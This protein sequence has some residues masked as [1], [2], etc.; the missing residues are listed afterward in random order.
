MHSP[1]TLVIFGAWYF[2]RVVAEAAELCSWTVAGF[3]DPEPPE[4]TA[5]LNT[6]P[7]DASV[8][9]AIGD[10]TMRSYVHSRL[11]DSGRTFAT[12]TH[13]TASV[14][15]SAAVE[16]GCYLGEFACVRTNASVGAGTVLNSGSVVSHDCQIGEFVTFGPNAAAAGRAVVGAR[17]TIGVGASVRPRAV[18]G[19]DCQVGAGAAVVSDITDGAVVGGVPAKVITSKATPDKQSAW[20]TNKTW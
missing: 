11:V 6:I 17:S 18:V 13:P 20:H 8:I 2:A 19:C 1:K 4:G 3:V 12:I 7:G 9:V 16:P 14:S 5:A 10:N 15:A